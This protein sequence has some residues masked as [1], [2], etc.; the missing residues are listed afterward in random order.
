MYVICKIENCEN[1]CGESSRHICDICYEKFLA[2]EI[3]F[4]NYNS[5][6]GGNVHS[7]LLNNLN[8]KKSNIS[9]DWLLNPILTIIGIIIGLLYYLIKFA[10][11]AVC[12]CFVLLIYR[13]I[14]LLII[15]FFSLL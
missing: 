6:C 14:I 2:G 15:K 4:R 5:I 13:W 12:L 3:S 7:E 10:A 9:L 8:T 11:L 1:I